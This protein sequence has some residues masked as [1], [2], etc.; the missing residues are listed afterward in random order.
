MFIYQFPSKIYI[1]SIIT[2]CDVV[3]PY[4]NKRLL[5]MATTILNITIMTSEEQCVMFCYY[6][7]PGCL[8]V[9][10]IATN[11]ITRCEMTTGLSNETDMVDDSTS[12][13]YVSGKQFQKIYC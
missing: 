12:V 8:A 2:G 6:E 4:Q 10:I 11:D 5:A 1:R 3:K 7:T 9:N 13:L